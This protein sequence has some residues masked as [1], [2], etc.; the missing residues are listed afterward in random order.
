MV[1]DFIHRT[2]CLHPSLSLWLFRKPFFLHCC[3]CYQIH[4]RCLRACIPL[5]AGFTFVSN[6]GEKDKREKKNH[7]ECLYTRIW[8]ILY[9]RM[10]NG[11][12]FF[13]PLLIFY[14]LCMHLLF[15]HSLA[16]PS[17]SVFFFFFFFLKCISREDLTHVYTYI[18]YFCFRFEFFPCAL[19]FIRVSLHRRS[20]F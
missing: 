19:Y 9:F 15:I 8:I 11:H 3:M 13:F 16:A 6:W 4:I 12:D 2:L 17:F 5:S 18:P 7:G 20:R 1:Q 14:V 10:L